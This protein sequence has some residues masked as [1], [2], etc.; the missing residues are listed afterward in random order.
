MDSDET[1]QLRQDIVGNQG[2]LVRIRERE[3]RLQVKL[4]ALQEEV[5][6]RKIDVNK[7]RN[8]QETEDAKAEEQ[9]A[10][11]ADG[12]ELKARQERRRYMKEET[13]KEIVDK[14]RIQMQE[15]EDEM[16]IGPPA[17]EDEGKQDQA[18]EKERFHDTVL[19]RYRPNKDEKTEY[20]ASFRCDKETKFRDV[21]KD[22]CQY[23][24]C[25]QISY[26]GFIF[27]P[28]PGPNEEVK[29]ESDWVAK[30]YPRENDA[31]QK[32]NDHSQGTQEWGLK[33]AA[34]LWLVHNDDQ[35]RK[36]NGYRYQKEQD[37]GKSKAKEAK[38]Q[39]KDEGPKNEVHVPQWMQ[40]LKNNGWMGYFHEVRRVKQ[41]EEK[42]PA[43]HQQKLRLRD[44][45]VLALVTFC[46]VMITVQRTPND[47]Y[48]VSQG[49]HAAFEDPR[50]AGQFPE[51]NVLGNGSSTPAMDWVA[52]MND[53]Y[54]NKPFLP[55]SHVRT[56]PQ[57][58][59]FLAQT[60]PRVFTNTSALTNFTWVGTLRLRQQRANE[61]PC[62]RMDV[63]TELEQEDYVCLSLTTSKEIDQDPLKIKKDVQ[64]LREVLLTDEIG[65]FT[66]WENT[67]GPH[68][69]G[70]RETYNP[71]GYS[72]EWNYTSTGMDLYLHDI[73]AM[74]QY[75]WID[76][77][78][79]A[80][81]LEADMY[82]TA[83]ET[84]IS[85]TFLFE[86]PPSNVASTTK[87]IRPM[88]LNFDLASSD[89]TAKYLEYVRIGCGVY[90]FLEQIRHEIMFKLV[91]DKSCL[92]YSLTYGLIDGW[93]VIAIAISAF[94]RLTFHPYAQDNPEEAL[95]DTT[96]Y[97]AGFILEQ[98]RAMDGC[99]FLLSGMRFASQ[100][101]VG[102]PILVL[103]RMMGKAFKESIYYCFIFFPPL[104]GFVFLAHC[105]W[106][107]QLE[108]FSTIR[109]TFITMMVFV[110]GD[111]D[112]IAIGTTARYWTPVYMA[113]FFLI[114]SIF[115]INGFTGIMYLSFLK[116]TIQENDPW[117]T[118]D[119]R[120][121]IGEWCHWAIPPVVKTKKPQDD[122]D[123]EPEANGKE[124]KVEDV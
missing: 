40:M 24:G 112:L 60:V 121:T 44:M 15:D 19:I 96:S 34:E 82:D 39:K 85:A 30:E 46:S 59:T 106:F 89:S 47:D 71:T 90:L 92:R 31:D 122:D 4:K 14:L 52:G 100:L 20:V 74:F 97:G 88:N 6:Q 99:I 61:V 5:D 38:S 9:K 13:K 108:E 117:H 17:L 66:E 102:K 79:R 53:F 55:F 105:I 45:F 65:K 123:D 78:T 67:A 76:S 95:L 83:A 115:M 91:R 86:L 12:R 43:D 37:A 64:A 58:Y 75:N 27:L 32:I 54:A 69:Q 84:Y 68:V 18:K 116:A 111:I 29:H 35:W 22:A 48:W 109:D 10:E 36:M 110:R 42:A 50:L 70:I 57:V 7:I 28:Q 94:V 41:R 21:H 1:T 62:Q 114:I 25:S 33:A 16:V 26:K 101:R 107:A 119:H 103:L 124:G 23:W 63:L 49:V 81:M 56:T 73:Y 3:K 2:E 93:L 77:H 80:I 104:C 51:Y 98:L 72:V 113:A 11:G 120:W 8:E 87:I 118:E